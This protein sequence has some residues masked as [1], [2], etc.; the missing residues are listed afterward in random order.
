MTLGLEAGADSYLTR[1]VEAPVLLATVRTLLFARNADLIRRGLDAK[2][3]TIF[4]LAPVYR[5][6]RQTFAIRE[7]QSRVLRVDRL[8]ADE[9]IGLSA[10]TVFG[11]SARIFEFG[12][13]KG[14]FPP[15]E[16][17]N[18]TRKDGTMAQVELRL[19]L[20]EFPAPALLS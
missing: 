8:R 13:R 10:A 18:F 5:D 9:L 7:C 20:E 6:A 14:R 4:S 19:A 1:P 17:L 15:N 16:Q 2:L 11:E 3:R 12:Q